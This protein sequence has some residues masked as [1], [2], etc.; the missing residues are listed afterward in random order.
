MVHDLRQCDA[1]SG[2]LAQHL[3][4]E[5]LQVA[6]HHGSAWEADVLCADD[7]VQTHDAWM[8]ERHCACKTIYVLSVHQNV[9]A[10]RCSCYH[11]VPRLC[12]ATL[13][14][15]PTFGYWHAQQTITSDIVRHAT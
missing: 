2:V 7:I 15:L 6:G 14:V 12:F 9:I 10:K 8:L 5:N 1:V 11:R 3:R 4:Y 13:E